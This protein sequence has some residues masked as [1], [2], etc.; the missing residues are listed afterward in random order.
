MNEA[1][2]AKKIAIEKCLLDLLNEKHRVLT[3]NER[4][5]DH[6][7]LIDGINQIIDSIQKYLDIITSSNFKL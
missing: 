5:V 3:S 6:E 1:N 7:K 2:E 4:S